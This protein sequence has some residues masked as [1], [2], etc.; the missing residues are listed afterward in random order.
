MAEVNVYANNDAKPWISF[1]FQGGHD[2][3]LKNKN[4]LKL[5]ITA[6][7]SFTKYVNGAYQ[8]NIPNKPLIQG[9][10]SSTGSYIGLSL[11][12]VFTNANHRIRKA[13]EKYSI[14]PEKT[15]PDP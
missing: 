8:V 9:T 4:L 2:W 1:P 13:Y 15:N 6:N 7:I 12:Y 3:V 11:S 14:G 10:C 5:A